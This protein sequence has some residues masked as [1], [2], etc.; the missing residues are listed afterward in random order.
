M[1][2]SVVSRCFLTFRSIRDGS[3]PAM[4]QTVCPLQTRFPT[5][6][7]T[8]GSRLW[9]VLLLGGLLMSASAGLAQ[10]EPVG[11]ESEATENGSTEDPQDVDRDVLPK[12][13]EMQRPPSY[14]EL[15]DAEPFD[16][17]VLRA[18]GQVIVCEPMEPR[19]DTLKKIQDEHDALAVR[20]RRTREENARLSELRLPQIYLPGD[21]QA[22]RIRLDSID[23]II[24]IEQLMLE[25]AALLI[26]EE[27][28][29]RAYDL[30]VR[31]QELVPGWDAAEQQYI[32]LLIAEAE[33]HQRHNRPYAGL[34]LLEQVYDL[35]DDH[36]RLPELLKSL[37]DPLIA[38]AIEQQDYSRARGLLTRW[39][40]TFPRV[41]DNDHWRKT[42]QDIADR[43]LAEAASLQRGGRLREAAV[44]AREAGRIWDL[45]RQRRNVLGEIV[46]RYQIVRVGV[47]SLDGDR[48]FPVPL[49]PVR[50]HRELTEEPLF[51]VDRFQEVTY[52]R[53][54]FIEDWDPQDLGRSV[55]FHLRTSRPW[56]HPQPL[57]K[58]GQIADALSRR[59][60]PDSDEYDPR[61]ASFVA[62]FTVK[63]PTRLEVRFSR[64]PLSLAALFR[65]LIPAAVDEDGSEGNPD[66]SAAG[67]PVV[68]GF[69]LR[70][71]GDAER[72]YVR[73]IPEPDGMNLLQ[74]HVAEIVEEP[75]EN[76]D[77]MIRAWRRGRI[78]V[79]ASVRP[80][81]V[82]PLRSSE[83]ES[84]FVQQQA[85]PASHVIV[86][87][88]QSDVLR[89]PQLRRALSLSVPREEILKRIVLRDDRGRH[90]RVTGSV[91]PA[92]SY[93]SD[94]RGQVVEYNPYLAFALRFAALERLRIPVR[95]KLVAAAREQ[96]LKSGG[97][98]DETV[99]REQNRALLEEA[100]ADIQLPQLTLLCEPD[101]VME[102]AAETM[103]DLWTRIGIPV[104]LKVPQAS[105][106]DIPDWDLMY[107]RV[108][109]QEPLLD[110]WSVLLT[111]HTLDVNLLE[112]FP[113]WFRQDL[114][115]LDFVGSF[116]LARDQLFRMQRNMA[117]QAFLIPLWEVDQF[118]AFRG[119]VSGYSERPVSVYDRVSRWV[120][121][122]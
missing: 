96:V 121:K 49:P 61:L 2:R 76:R 119:Q 99:W 19:P 1:R 89:H 3:V 112:P 43:T 32:A 30:I 13:E 62:G 10:E 100:T 57:I 22:Y 59:L 79:I 15:I 25:R 105:D 48:P 42:L 104:V 116:R 6:R 63:S 64:V 54:A 115:L 37:Y 90:G 35:Q 80:W 95:Q 46:A 67:S 118:T 9:C 41:A 122:P 56:W 24:G 60:D 111:D 21:P 70:E 4:L 45:P 39:S 103:V 29:V 34:A 26:E 77:D 38:Q 52:Y 12:L 44:R 92:S 55:T 91:W 40:D 36:P 78:D 101:P 72:S 31:V 109:M 11:S 87:N 33:F 107:R 108:W 28:F 83:N 71:S 106:T 66:A 18:S 97:E 85:I 113:D 7:R 110:V 14:D 8:A 88:P 73:R 102:A 23:Q 65:M 69:R 50:R 120:V 58:A 93:A 27:D 16:W 94:P 82:D 81:E 75:F 68:G 51:S 20:R 17:I 5:K 117:A 84:G 53:S 86:F 74:Y 114:T 98:W 47:E